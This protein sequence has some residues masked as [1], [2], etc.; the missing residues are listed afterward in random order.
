MA[1]LVRWLIERRGVAPEDIV[2]LLRSNRNNMWSKP[3]TEALQRFSIPVVNPGAVDA[4]LAEPSN[5]RLLAI[6]RLVV[7]RADS[8]AW[9]TIFDLTHGIGPKVRDHFYEGARAAG[10][11]FGAQLLSENADGFFL[12]T[13]RQRLVA[14]TVGPVLD[15]VNSVDLEGADLGDHGWG[16]WLARQAPSLGGCED[17]FKELLIDIDEIVDRTTG[18]RGLLSQIRPVGKDIRSGRAAGAVRLMSMSGSKGLT[19]KATLIMGVEDGVI[20]HPKADPGE[21]R[22]LLYVAMTR[23]TDYL[24]LTWAGKR[25]GPTARTGATNVGQGRNRSPLLT[26]GPVNSESGPNYLRTLGA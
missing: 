13:H 24:Y 1:R 15:L 21:E 20:P 25:A 17:A 7:N 4:M 11:T 14:E 5:R 22:R 23:A 26:Y 2:I 12:L 10:T 9:W 19:V 16:T 8:L 18:L 3:I 6:A